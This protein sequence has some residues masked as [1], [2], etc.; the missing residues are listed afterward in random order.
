MPSSPRDIRPDTEREPLDDPGPIQDALAAAVKAYT[1]RLEEEPDLQPFRAE[2]GITKTDAA[3]L[4]S[5]V[6]RMAEMEL[7]ELSLFES[8][9][10]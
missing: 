7:F 2:H 1:A 4:A 6:L 3:L 10:R 8:W 5:R 9:H